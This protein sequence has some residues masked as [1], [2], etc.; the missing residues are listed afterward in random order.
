MKKKITII[1]PVFNEE[2][3]INDF[4]DAFYIIFKKLYLLITR[5]QII[6]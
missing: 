5:A 2:K 4:Y 3:N 6:A 1:C